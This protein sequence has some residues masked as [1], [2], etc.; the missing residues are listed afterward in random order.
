MKRI[1]LI[2]LPLW[3]SSHA[4]PADAQ[5]P[6]GPEP[7]AARALPAQW[8]AVSDRDVF[9]NAARTAWAYVDG[10]Y[11]AQTGLVNSVEGYPFATVWD[12][13]SGLLA[14]YSADQLDLLDGDEY[15]RRMRR[16]L[17]TLAEM[18]LFDG[19]AFNKMYSTS[20]GAISGRAG[21]EAST[22]ER[23]YGWSVLDIGRLLVALKVI[24]ANQP[25]YAELIE[26][27]VGRLD[28]GRLIRDGYLR[29]EDLSPRGGRKRE[30]QE[31]R[32][33]YEQYA[34]TGFAAWGHRADRALDL[35]QNTR[36]V[37]VLGV[38]LL[39][40]TRQGSHLT[41]DPFVM[42]GLEIG[43]GAEMRELA[44][45]VLAAQEAR[46]RQTGTVTIVNEDAVTG[47]PYFLYYSVL[48]DDRE[49]A[50]E[51]PE[52]AP[53]GP[54][55]R[56]VSTKGAYGWHALVPSGYTWAALQRVE[57]ARTPGGW[58]AG[59]FEDD[60]RVSGGANVNTAAVVMEAALYVMRGGRPLIEPGPERGSVAAPARAA[61]G[62]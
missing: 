39:N 38:P 48:A 16:A 53:A 19:A 47:P 43:W 29:G 61:A 22:S 37:T 41:S 5:R 30:Y 42:H 54:V 58:G 31:G 33:G 45:R 25:Q 57:G 20:S 60:G 32:V 28:Y 56:T 26:T 46:W 24:H 9:L 23:G 3:V 17:Q 15:D 59:V 35:R 18:R 40:D 34:A 62:R 12:I 6:R 51:A 44:W 49:F 13:G 10:Q 8:G 4:A 50:A 21:Q 7:A 55:R 2:V 1:F 11:N 14:L 27:V 52:G 36:P